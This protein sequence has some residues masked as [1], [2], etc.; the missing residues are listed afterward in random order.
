[1]AVGNRGKCNR[2]S[3]PFSIQKVNCIFQTGRIPTIVLRS[4]DDYTV[5]LPDLVG[6]RMHGCCW[7]LDIPE[8]LFKNW[9]LIF[10]EVKHVSH[11]QLVHLYII[12]EE[13]GNPVAVAANPYA[14]G[15]NS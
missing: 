1:M 4:N 10:L 6:E 2:F 12:F 3:F 5:C 9:K 15:N 13:Q 14:G 7:I 11:C 8:A